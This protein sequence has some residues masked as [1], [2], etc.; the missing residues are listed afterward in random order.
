M[1]SLARG[2]AG[3]IVAAAFAAGPAAAGL[4]ALPVTNPGFEAPDIDNPNGA[5]VVAPTGWL[6]TVGAVGAFQPV[7]PAVYDAIPGG[8]QV[9]YIQEFGDLYQVLAPLVAGGAYALSVKVGDRKDTAIGPV[10]LAFFAE[11]PAMPGSLAAAAFLIN[12]IAPPTV[13]GD[14]VTATLDYLAPAALGALAGRNLIVALGHGGQAGQQANFDDVALS[15]FTADPPG[16]GRIAEPGALA[17]FGLG[18]AGLWR[19]RRRG[20]ER[21]RPLHTVAG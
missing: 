1:F 13:D 7:T 15:L 3:L 8:D 2:L 20:P 4:V 11:D 16:N 17:L 6:S 9:A 19:I 14:F 10:L 18:L 5:T 12:A 21:R